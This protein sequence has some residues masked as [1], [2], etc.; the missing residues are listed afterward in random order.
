MRGDT[1]L[2]EALVLVFN[3][4]F[5]NEVW[6][7][8][9]GSGVIVPLHKHD[10]RLLPSNYRPITLMSVV[11][12]LFG[13]VVNSRLQQFS[14]R[15]GT[16]SDE[17]GGFRTHRGTVDQVFL[18]REILASRKERGGQ[19]YTTFID[20]RKAYD[21]V[22]REYAYT[23][24][25]DSGVQGKLWRQLQAMHQGLKRK[26]RHPLGM[27][28]EFDV[29]RG[30][31]QGAVES[32]WVYSNFIDG[33]AQ[34]L[35]DAGLG[36]LVAGRRVPLLMYA[37]D[38]VLLAASLPELDRMNAVAT[39]FARQHRFQ[40]NG[41]KSGVML[42][43]AGKAERDRAAAHKWV[44]FGEEVEVK[45]VY[46]Y[47]GT[48][49]STNEGWW[50][51]HLTAAIKKARRRSTDLLW[52]CR[53][54][55]GMRSRTAIVLWQAMV[56]PILE[57]ASE[58]WSGQIPAYLAKEAEE[59]QT[60]FL[61]G[62]LGLHA[63]GGGV[64][65]DVVRAEAGCEALADRWAKLK[66]GYWRRLFVASPDRLLLLVAKFRHA[67]LAAGAGYGSRGWMLTARDAL[68]QHGMTDAW[69]NTTVAVGTNE[70]EWR[71]RVY[72][73]IEDVS[74]TRLHTRLQAM[75]SASEYRQTK[76]WERTPAVYAF[77][78]GEV[79][80]RGRLTP[81]RYLDDRR[82]LKGTRLKLLCRLGCLPVMDRVGREARPP[83]PKDFRGC[84]MCQKDKVES[85]AHFVSECPAYAHQRGRLHGQVIRALQCS[86][87]DV[88]ADAYLAMGAHTQTRVLF[89]K[90]LGDPVTED[91]VDKHVKKFLTK[92]W[93]VRAGMTTAVNTVMGTTY[94]V[95][96][97]A[98]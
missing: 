65:N 95:C 23:R 5:D 39:K 52:V 35:K 29:D 77:S 97:R 8:R 78:T 82:C 43:N 54:D 90:R 34:A 70:F 86:A 25:H 83:W 21:T 61:R 66:L 67:E 26:V 1:G 32:P 76:A 91:R 2:V 72:D 42:F 36:V 53:S 11:G 45:K 59:V 93:N 20:A 68:Q 15:M 27:T 46:V 41:E 96:A 69:T 10:S 33:L 92:A 85:V 18:L 22:W 17:Q 12:K 60:V 74:D 73:A 55:K 71:T 87:G 13:I 58:L 84:M 94:D 80:R 47:L 64:S 63:N 49:T 37:D 38:I 3:Y 31:A 40:F 79:G 16:I 81:E 48:A 57:Y 30:V 98:S 51:A 7:E 50:T 56:R 88:T 9:W 14:E 19:T 75:P 44:L 28:E 89:G 24:I 6:P 62:T 4:V